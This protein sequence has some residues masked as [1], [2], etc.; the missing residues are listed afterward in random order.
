MLVWSICNI[1]VHVQAVEVHVH[2]HYHSTL[3]PYI[4]T[5]QDGHHL[6]NYNKIHDKITSFC[7]LG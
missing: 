2:S 1:Y 7:E 3:S 4:I 6:V 5:V